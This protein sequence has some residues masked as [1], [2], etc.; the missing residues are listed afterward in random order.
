MEDKNWFFLKILI[1]KEL[2]YILD[3]N[4]EIYAMFAFTRISDKLSKK[5]LYIERASAF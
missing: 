3:I 1:N 2:L 4:I 5:K